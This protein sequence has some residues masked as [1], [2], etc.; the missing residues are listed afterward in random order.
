MKKVYERTQERMPDEESRQGYLDLFNE[1]MAEREAADSN[2]V[3]SRFEESL[4]DAEAG[5]MQ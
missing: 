4:G 5:S 1:V 2:A 3:A